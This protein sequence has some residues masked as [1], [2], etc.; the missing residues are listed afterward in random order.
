MGYLRKYLEPVLVALIIFSAIFLSKYPTLYHFQHQPENLFFS[1]QASWFDAWD[2]N[3]YVSYIRYGQRNGVML[4]NTYT[5]VPHQPVFVFQT[6]T[7]LGVLNRYIRLDPFLLF[8]LASVLTGILLMLSIYLILGAVFPE[9]YKRLASFIIIVLGGGLGWLNNTAADYRIAGFTLVDPLERPHNALSTLLLLSSV[10]LFAY[11]LEKGRLEYFIYSLFSAFILFTIHPPL[12]LLS[13]L[14]YIAG[15]FFLSQRVNRFKRFMLLS[16]LLLAYIAYFFLL[17]HRFLSNGGFKGL[18]VQTIWQPDLLSIIFG[19]G[20]LS[21]GILTAILVKEKNISY[22]IIKIAFILH[23][24]LAFSPLGFHMYFFKGVFIWGVILGVLGMEGIFKNFLPYWLLLV[25]SLS[26]PL[27]L[28][29][30]KILRSPNYSNQF[31]Y[32][33]KIEGQSLKQLVTLPKDSSVLSLYRIGNY[34]PAFTDNRVF[35]GHS[36]QTPDFNQKLQ[37]AEKFYLTDD[38]NFQS[39]FLKDNRIDYVYV[40]LEEELLRKNN[41]L[42][43]FSTPDFLKPVF[44][45]N[46]IALY[47]VV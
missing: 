29:I 42:L 25:L 32:L 19:F 24:I 1:G 30:F 28:Q 47:K 2:I 39:S 11:F 44:R 9:F 12:A 35:L 21:I 4:K 38:G 27:R 40:G 45:L 43:L 18:V 7:L 15:L 34:I 14:I 33:Q 23:L 36:I 26:L 6:Y 3:S 16:L 8:H 5:T 22:K 46:G 41:R 31:Y 10:Y 20:L 13:V 37:L 17:L